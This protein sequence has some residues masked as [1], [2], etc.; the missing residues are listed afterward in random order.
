MFRTAPRELIV[1]PAPAVH[2]VNPTPHC[3]P[4]KIVPNGNATDAFGGIVN[5]FA[6]ATFITTVTNGT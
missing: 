2:V 6:V 4:T 5:V 3:S 1:T